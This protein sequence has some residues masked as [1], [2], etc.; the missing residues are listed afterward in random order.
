MET[1]A[2]AFFHKVDNETLPKCF[3]TNFRSDG[4]W[5]HYCEQF[6]TFHNKPYNSGIHF[7]LISFE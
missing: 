2:R 3:R 5:V 6:S 4:Q 7:P 1:A